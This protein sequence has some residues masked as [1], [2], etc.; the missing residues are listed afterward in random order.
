M[1]Q[2]KDWRKQQVLDSAIATH[3]AR[4]STLQI[5]DSRRQLHCCLCVTGASKIAANQAWNC[6]RPHIIPCNVLR[7][8]I[9][10]VI[11]FASWF[12]LE[13]RLRHQH[14]NTPG[15]GGSQLSMHQ[16]SNTPG[17]GGSQLSIGGGVE[18]WF[19]LLRQPCST[20][21]QEAKASRKLNLTC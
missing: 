4:T 13:M 3:A 10:D 20:S 12:E 6:T 1:S 9:R 8:I 11:G 5:R 15:M 21:N 2:R 7:G 16:H 17:M 14:S 19:Q 18:I